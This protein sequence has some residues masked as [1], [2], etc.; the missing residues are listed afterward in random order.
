MDQAT[1]NAIALADELIELHR[2]L[3]EQ[4]AK[5]LEASGEDK[6][7]SNET[8]SKLVDMN[9]ETLLSRTPRSSLGL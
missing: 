7:F 1:R 6:L 4:A 2:D 3:W 5:D 8:P 9:I